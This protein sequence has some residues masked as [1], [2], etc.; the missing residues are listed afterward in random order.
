M[1][2]T[3]EL[4]FMKELCFP[5]V[6]V[7]VGKGRGFR[8]VKVNVRL[9]TQ[10]CKDWDTLEEKRMY[11]FGAS[12]YIVGHYGQC[13]DYIHDNAEKYMIPKEMQELYNRIYHIWKE[14]HLNNLQSGTKKQTEMLTKEL[15]KADNYTEACKHLETIGLLIDRGYKYGTSWLCK[16][17]PS[18]IVAEIMTWQNI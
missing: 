12:A 7:G 18:E 11:V 15:H 1:D 4:I 3:T 14:Y 17:I 6:C 13:L 16:E 9:E 2:N 5:T 10:I 8:T